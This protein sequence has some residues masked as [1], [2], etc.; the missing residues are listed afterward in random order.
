MI[1]CACLPRKPIQK[2]LFSRRPVTHHRYVM[3]HS[4]NKI[5]V[6][7]HEYIYQPGNL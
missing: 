7:R 4:Q 3:G 6:A 2:A 5:V 1:I